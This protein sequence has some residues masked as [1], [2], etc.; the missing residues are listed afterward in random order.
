MVTGETIHGLATIR[1]FGDQ[2]TV[3]EHVF[4]RTLSHPE[5]VF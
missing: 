4:L 3:L 5:Q 1:S 2:V